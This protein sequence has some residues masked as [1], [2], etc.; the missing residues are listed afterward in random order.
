MHGTQ[1]FLQSLTTGEQSVQLEIESLGR[2]KKFLSWETGQ[3]YSKGETRV[4][5]TYFMQ[6]AVYFND[7]KSSAV[8]TGTKFLLALSLI[9]YTQVKEL[10]A[11]NESIIDQNCLKC[12][13]HI[14]KMKTNQTKA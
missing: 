4:K 7:P 10:S 8:T 14:P 9:F 11:L 12:Q 13:I 5:Y 6:L 3:Y 2:A 1:H